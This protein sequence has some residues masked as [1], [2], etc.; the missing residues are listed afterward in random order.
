[1]KPELLLRK[2]APNNREYR[3]ILRHSKKVAEIALRLASRVKQPVDKQL[4]Y[5]G[6][7]LHDIGRFIHPPGCQSVWHGVAGAEIM[8]R[9]GYPKI[10]LICE[11]HLGAG[12]TKEEAVKHGLP[13]RDYLPE[14]IEE[15]IV[16]YADKLVSG[17]REISFEKALERFQNELG[18]TVAKRLLKLHNEIISLSS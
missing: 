7:M 5:L 6:A 12:I 13:A 15:K 1:M 3:I 18:S 11:R 16:C 17:S 14:S 10:A 2:Y 9:E 8:R 4:V